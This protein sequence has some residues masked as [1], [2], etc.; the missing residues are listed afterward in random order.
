MGEGSEW[1]TK[2]PPGLR[3]I[4]VYT[5]PLS[6]PTLAKKAT[7]LPTNLPSAAAASASAVLAPSLTCCLLDPKSNKYSG[8]YTIIKA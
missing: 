7:P 1:E 2:T 8:V 6:T 5:S 4:Y 3:D